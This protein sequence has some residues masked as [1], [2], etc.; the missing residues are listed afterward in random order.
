VHLLGWLLHATNSPVL[1]RLHVVVLPLCHP[2]KPILGLILP[3]SINILVCKI[4]IVHVLLGRL[5][6][7][8]IFGADGRNMPLI[9]TNSHAVF[10]IKLNEFSRDYANIRTSISFMLLI[11]RTW[12][13]LLNIVGTSLLII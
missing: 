7:G 2:I 10:V 9:T 13:L 4:I 1:I 6:H 3:I 8:L 11:W 12:V 5:G